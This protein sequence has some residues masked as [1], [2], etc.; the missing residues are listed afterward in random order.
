MLHQISDLTVLVADFLPF[1]LLFNPSLFFAASLASLT[2]FSFSNCSC[3]G[4]FGTSSGRTPDPPNDAPRIR[5]LPSFSVS[6]IMGDAAGRYLYCSEY[7]GHQRPP[8]S[9]LQQQQLRG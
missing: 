8:Q 9:T 4:L 2:I 5:S 1:L 7:L 3:T 6:V